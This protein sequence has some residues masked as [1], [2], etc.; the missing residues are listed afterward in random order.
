VAEREQE[1]EVKKEQEQETREQSPSD[2]FSAKVR[3]A[4]ERDA[5]EQGLGR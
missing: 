4:E 2:M 3:E 5:R 1:Q